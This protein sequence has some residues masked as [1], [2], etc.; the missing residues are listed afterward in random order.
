MIRK[1][2]FLSSG[3]PFM[4]N[5]LIGNL[6]KAGY[7]IASAEMHIKGVSRYQG[8]FDLAIVFLGDALLIHKDILSFLGEMCADA[9]KPLLLLGTAEELEIAANA[10]QDGVVTKRFEKPV[11]IKSL[12]DYLDAMNAGPE[13]KAPRKV[14]LVD[15]DADYLRMVSRWLSDKYRVVIVNSGTQAIGFL[16]SNRPDLILLDYNMP[17]TSG[18]QVLEM[19][20]SEKT[21]RE[22]PVIF[23]TGKDDSES[24]RR[25]LELKPNGYILKSVSKNELIERLDEFFKAQD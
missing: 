10:F 19:I 3:S 11:N 2:L 23:L 18:P 1:I 15:D 14:L 22:I 16:G 25:V 17:V 13:V 12:V 4:V 6:T 7:E 20:R 9:G 8:R 5:A 24:V 21:T